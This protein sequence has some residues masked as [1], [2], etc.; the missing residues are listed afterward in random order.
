MFYIMLYLVAIVLANLSVAQ[1]GPSVTIL[2]AFLFIGLDLT[3]R[4]KLHEV[5]RG[6][7]L[8][9][10]NGITDWCRFITVMVFES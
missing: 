3:A 9:L 4:D 8:V 6:N 2:N 5:W 10:K 1:F 7:R